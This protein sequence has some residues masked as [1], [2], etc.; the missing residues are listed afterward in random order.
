MKHIEW[1]ERIDKARAEA[2]ETPA[3]LELTPEEEEI[4]SRLPDW[5]IQ[6]RDEAIAEY[7]ADPERD[8]RLMAINKGFALFFSEQNIRSLDALFSMGEKRG[9]EIL[10]KEAK[11]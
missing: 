1:E 7:A 8:I 4:L 10:G 2:K 5:I 9:G 3:D 11:P 6:I